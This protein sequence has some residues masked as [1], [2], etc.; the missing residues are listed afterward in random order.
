MRI[1]L[2]C[3]GGYYSHAGDLAGYSTRD[4]TSA[5]G[6]RVVVLE[7][8]GDGDANGA[9]EVAKNAVIDQQF[10]ASGPR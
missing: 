1:P 3:G 6:R 9:T 4:G 5:D 8:T 10:C 7:A 2:S